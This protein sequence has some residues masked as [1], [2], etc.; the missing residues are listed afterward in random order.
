MAG[1]NLN[2]L[3]RRRLTVPGVKEGIRQS[4]YDFLTYDNAGHTQLRFFSEQIGTNS[5]TKADTN[6]T[7]S[8]Q[9]PQGWKFIVESI[10]MHVFPGN[11]ASGYTVEEIVS[12]PTTLAAPNFANDVYRLGQ[13]GYLDFTIGS[14][15]WLTE[16][17][18]MRFPPTTGIAL[19]AAV[20]V[21]TTAALNQITVDYAKFAGRPYILNPIIPIPPNMN[22]EITLNWPTALAT[23]S[24]FDLRVG[25]V[26]PGILFRD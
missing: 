16:G 18:L 25:V 2:K 17:P 13:S 1:A 20:A 22:F 12:A 14:K 23:V 4:L 11:T 8:G 3:Y 6:M 21:S 26:M 5:K 9:L 10:E 24:G 7:L 15:P 19:G